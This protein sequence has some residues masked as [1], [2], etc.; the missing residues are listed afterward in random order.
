V[1]LILDA[2]ALIWAVDDASKLGPLADSEIS[3]PATR[4]ERHVQ[5]PNATS[6]R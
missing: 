1:K 6:R 5:I 2:H 3:N 4:I